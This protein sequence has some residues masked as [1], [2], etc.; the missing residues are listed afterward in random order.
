MWLLTKAYV[1]GLIFVLLLTQ[2]LILGE[3]NI[4]AIIEIHPVHRPGRASHT[5]VVNIVN[6]FPRASSQQQRSHISQHDSI[7]SDSEQLLIHAAD[8]APFIG[9]QP[10]CFDVIMALQRFRSK[11]FHRRHYA[12]HSSIQNR[13]IIVLALVGRYGSLAYRNQLTGDGGRR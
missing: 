5:Q 9:H 11:T 2:W 7:I 4:I 13:W 8:D 6:W 12:P 10:P 3:V 1:R